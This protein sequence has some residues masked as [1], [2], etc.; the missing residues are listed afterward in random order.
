MAIGV[1]E[2][3]DAAPVIEVVVPMAD[4]SRDGM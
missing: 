3:L 2:R 4:G 1:I